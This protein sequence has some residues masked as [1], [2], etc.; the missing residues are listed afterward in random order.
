MK[1]NSSLKIRIKIINNYHVSNTQYKDIL[2]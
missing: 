1:A 2:K